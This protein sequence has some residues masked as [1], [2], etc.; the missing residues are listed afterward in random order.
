MPKEI[1]SNYKDNLNQGQI[2]NFL[3]LRRRKLAIYDDLYAKSEKQGLTPY[4]ITLSPTNNTI[5]ATLQLRKEFLSKLKDTKSNTNYFCS[6]ELGFKNENSDEY[7]Y[8]SLTTQQKLDT[9]NFHIHIQIWTD[10]TTKRVQNLL[11]KFDIYKSEY[12]QLTTPKKQNVKYT[13]VVKNLYTIDWKEVD[14]FKTN[15]DGVQV[16]TN[17]QND[18]KVF[19]KIYDYFK[20]FYSTWFKSKKNKVVQIN[21]LK[22]TNNI[23]ISNGKN[24]SYSRRDYDE[25]TIPNSKITVYI[26]KVIKVVKNIFLPQNVPY[27]IKRFNQQENS[28][29]S[30]KSS[31]LTKVVEVKNK[32]ISKYN[33]LKN[34]MTKIN[35]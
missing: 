19:T 29:K 12:K 27:K 26:R 10:L 17:T 33:H 23:V 9:P 20:K 35:M 11:D 18:S 7:K 30:A 6:I 15:C 4:M 28:V 5:E 8:A 2:D 3:K 16:Y 32:M 25:V 21:K 34:L 24:N 22:D 31:F 1:H 14:Y 13:Y